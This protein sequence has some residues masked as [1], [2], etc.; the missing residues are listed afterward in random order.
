MQPT[1]PA[2]PIAVRAFDPARAQL[3]DYLDTTVFPA[4][5]EV[6]RSM[7]LQEALDSHVVTEDTRLFTFEYQETL[8]AFPMRVVLAYNVMQ[9]QLEDRQPWLLTFCNACNTGTVFDPVV[10]GQLLHFKRRG[11]FDGMLLV[12]DEETGTYWQHI[13]GEGLYGAK[14]GSILRTIAHTRTMSAGEAIKRS[15]TALYTSTLNDMQTKLASF[16]EKMRDDPSRV[17]GTILTTV[18][19]DDDRRPRFELG[20]GIWNGNKSQFYPLIMLYDHNNAWFSTFNGQR[21]LVYQAPEAVSP[22]AVYTNADSARWEGDT[23]RFSDGT[24]LKDDALYSADGEKLTLTRPSQ[25]LMR[26]YGFALTFPGT[27][28]AK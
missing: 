14:R 12:W 20:L 16:A 9:G 11:A 22:V 7:P 3:E 26:W 19:K 10:D 24:H 21:T 2:S 18:E 25:L 17:A 4:R 8:Y 1:T 15:N 23:L 6:S 27:D 28:V 5:L 13:T